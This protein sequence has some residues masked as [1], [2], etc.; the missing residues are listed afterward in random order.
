MFL[1]IEV[2]YRWFE[3]PYGQIAYLL[4]K[5]TLSLT[6]KIIYK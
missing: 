6:S 4:V 5:S 1:Y 2:V 3:L